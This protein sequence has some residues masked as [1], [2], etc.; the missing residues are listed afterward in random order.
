METPEY[1]QPEDDGLL[2]ISEMQRVCVKSYIVVC[3][4]RDKNFP[5]LYLKT[6]ATSENDAIRKVGK[7]NPLVK[8][9]RAYLSK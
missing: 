3:I 7:E 1:F 4:R 2:L 8:V 9:L 6:E 5:L